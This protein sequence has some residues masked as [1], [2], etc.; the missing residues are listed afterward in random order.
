M[1]SHH[2]SHPHQLH[3]GGHGGEATG[4]SVVKA[5]YFSKIYQVHFL[6]LFMTQGPSARP[7]LCPHSLL[8]LICNG[9]ADTAEQGMQVAPAVWGQAAVQT[10]HFIQLTLLLPGS[11]Q[12][13][14]LCGAE[15]LQS[16]PARA[17]GGR[18]AQG[19]PCTS[20]PARSP[21]NQPPAWNSRDLDGP[22]MQQMPLDTD[23]LLR[24][25]PVPCEADVT[26]ALD[27]IALTEVVG[28]GGRS[29][30]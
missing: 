13:L 8:L 28:W 2:P 24:G 11:L 23:G 26:G 27:D 15:P 12:E 22:M 30:L 9:Q 21:R 17:G 29:S 7:L 3:P 18:V 4:Q 14:V 5:F 25:D 19:E 16:L 1:G 10:G 20:L 6:N